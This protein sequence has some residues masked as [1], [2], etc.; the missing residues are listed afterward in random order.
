MPFR[1]AFSTLGCPQ[2][3]LAE[4]FALAVRHGVDAIELR[5]LGGTLD[6]PDYFSRH[7]GEPAKFHAELR[8]APVAVPV[9]DT[10]FRLIGS[11]ETERGA[12][13]GFVPWAEAAGVPWLR[14]FDGG[15]TNGAPEFAERVATMA[16]WQALRSQ[17]EWRTDLLVET[18]DALFSAD[19]IGQCAV[20]RGVT[21]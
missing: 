15:K 2:L 17:H 21:S 3:E 10:S 1:R 11:G 4:A 7:F 6:L 20:A 14:V 18:H 9:I 16:W 13:L 12:L 5:A 8:R 19:A